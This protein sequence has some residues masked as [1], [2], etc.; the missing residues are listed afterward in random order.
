MKIARLATSVR[1]GPSPTSVSAYELTNF[2]R[3]FAANSLNEHAPPREGS[4]PLIVSRQDSRPRSGF[5]LSLG[6]AY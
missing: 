1:L 5:D 2:R 6:Y 4:A 3:S